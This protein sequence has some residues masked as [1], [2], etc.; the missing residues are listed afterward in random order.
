MGTEWCGKTSQKA[1]APSAVAAA[2]AKHALAVGTVGWNVASGTAVFASSLSAKIESVWER[3]AFDLNSRESGSQAE[4]IKCQKEM[5][6]VVL[7]KPVIQKSTLILALTLG[8]SLHEMNEWMNEVVHNAND[9]KTF[10]KHFSDCLFY[11]FS[12]YADCLTDAEYR[13][14]KHR[15]KMVQI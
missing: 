14:R 10:L 4:L 1:P 2:A 5:D 8:L 7:L 6:T 9:A 11:F 15:N 12:A 3:D 13:W